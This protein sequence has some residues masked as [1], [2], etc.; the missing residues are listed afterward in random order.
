MSS[1]INY[2]NKSYKRRRENLNFIFIGSGLENTKSVQEMLGTM[3]H[4]MEQRRNSINQNIVKSA[5][6]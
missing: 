5:T 3:K 6:R 4:S 2:V 1:Q